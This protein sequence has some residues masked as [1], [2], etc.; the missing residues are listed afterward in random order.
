MKIGFL[1]KSPFY[2][3][4]EQRVVS[5]IASALAQN[6]YEVGILYTA[7]DKKVNRDLYNLDERVELYQL[8]GKSKKYSIKRICY[9]ALKKINKDT[10]FF[11]KCPKILEKI[12]YHRDEK[13]LR[14][15]CETINKNNFDIVIG[16][17]GFFSVTLAILKEKLN[18]KVFGWQHN[19]YEAYFR[20]KNRYY[21][22]QDVIFEKY[23]QKLD[24]YIVL[25]NYDKKNMKKYFSLESK[26][27]NN[28]RSFSSKEKTNLSNKT[29]LSLGRLEDAKGYDL[30]LESFK[31]F[32]EENE[33]WNLNIVGE[34]SKEEYIKSKLKE[35]NLQN[36]VT[37]YPFT[38][39]V[40]KYLKE[41]SIFL[42]PSK[43]EGFGLV[44]LEA[45]EMGLPVIAYEL[46]P[47]QEIIDDKQNGYLVEKFDTAKYA[48]CMLNIVENKDN[49]KK[50]SE[51]AIKKSEKYSIENIVENWKE[52]LC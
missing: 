11:K 17:S 44:I 32:A 12:Y 5:V 25:T 4:G 28:P 16:S 8:K 7:F 21:W 1:M 47:V 20:T 22:H 23:L 29:F 37:L 10:P 31:T 36:R 9:K 14:N 30:L 6:G 41:A 48:K 26:V 43:W 45:F 46:G 35:Y 3:G 34:G 15:I 2:F 39:D 51:N 42:L 18:C 24:E 52:I 19:C 49:L 40:K 27:I 33:E 50:M 13:L 38:N